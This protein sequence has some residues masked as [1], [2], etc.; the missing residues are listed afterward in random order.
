MGSPEEGKNDVLSQNQ[1][2]AVE[3]DVSVPEP[4][5]YFLFIDQ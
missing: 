3:D 1:L 4:T 5:L 2:G